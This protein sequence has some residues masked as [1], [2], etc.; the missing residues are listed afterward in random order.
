[1]SES[2]SNLYHWRGHSGSHFPTVEAGQLL[3]RD[4]LDEAARVIAQGELRVWFEPR[5]RDARILAGWFPLCLVCSIP[6]ESDTESLRK[7]PAWRMRVDSG[8]RL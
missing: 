3:P 5:W 1:M 4:P 8:A 6:E 2:F 7:T